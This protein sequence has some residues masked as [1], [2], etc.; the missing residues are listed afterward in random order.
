[1]EASAGED[2]TLRRWRITL[3][4]AAWLLIV[5]SGITFIAGLIVLFLAP[6]A[7][8]STLYAQ[9]GTVLD[10]SHI[11]MIQTLVG[12]TLFLN[13]I[14]TVGSLILLAGSIGLL[15]HKKWGWYMVVIVH[16]A[17]VV[18]VF[19]WVMPMFE[20]LYRAFDPARGGTIALAMTMLAVL[21][22]A[23]VVAFLLL[24]PVVSQLERGT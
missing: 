20:T 1:M 24:R 14:Q 19:I 23:V 8:Q 16:V 17:A 13:R 3:T 4:V 10:R 2:Q 9:L 6:F 12:Q 11:A 5:Q 21:A 7:A 15:L 22:P 18:A